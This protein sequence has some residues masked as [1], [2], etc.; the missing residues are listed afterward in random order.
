M[1][2]KVPLDDPDPLSVPLSD[3][4]PDIVK[5]WL[6]VEV[7]LGERDPVDDCEFVG[8]KP[9]LIVPVALEDPENVATCVCV[10]DL[11]GVPDRLGVIVGLGESVTLALC[12]AVEDT[13]SN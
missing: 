12:D 10:S 7:W 1:Q 5:N 6:E 9:W 11:P 3:G 2:L 8:V 13:V 4:V